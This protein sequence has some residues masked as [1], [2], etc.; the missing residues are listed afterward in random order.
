MADPAPN[1]NNFDDATKVRYCLPQLLP[2]CRVLIR[3]PAERAEHF[4]GERA[5]TTTAEFIY[6]HFYGHVLGQVR[7]LFIRRR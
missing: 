2:T 5:G 1:F 6:P 4:H 7:G 3:S